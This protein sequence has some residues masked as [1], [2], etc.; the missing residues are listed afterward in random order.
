MATLAA[1]WAAQLDAAGPVRVATTVIGLL[2][3]SVWVHRAQV[4]RWIQTHF[5]RAFHV[6]TGAVAPSAA[7]RVVDRNRRASLA[8]DRVHGVCRVLCLCHPAR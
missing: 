4:D 5:D 1:W 7:Q 6:D 2:C 3:A 8:G